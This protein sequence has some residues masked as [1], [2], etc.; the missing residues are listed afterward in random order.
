MKHLLSLHD[1]SPDA[2]VSVLDDADELKHTRNWHGAARPL[3]GRS[4]AMIFSKSSTRTRVSFEVGIFELGGNA[5]F[6]DRKAL[7]LGRGEPIADTA[8]VLSRYV[9]AIVIRYHSHADVEELAAGSAVPVINALTDRYHPCQ[10][11]ADLQTIRQHL[12]RLSG[13]KV[14]YLGDGASNMA[15]SWILGAGL[16]GIDLTVGAPAPYQ[17]PAELLT[18]VA[19]NGSV[20]VE[21]DP[22]RAVAGADIVY[23]DV[24]VSM[25]F[26]E[27]AEERLQ[28]LAP[29]QV[30]ADLLQ[31][32]AADV[33]V[34]HCLPA[35]RDKEI[36]A[37][38]LE[39]ERA[40]V[41][42]QAENRL[43]AQKA[44]LSRLVS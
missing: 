36:T 34:M 5:M 13:V 44:I 43:H 17:P 12:G 29:Y 42:D 19:G 35:Y 37:D 9:H 24:W 23:T 39:S 10:V 28:T 32:A 26:E 21:P 1:L 11:L 15:A 16:A 27:E 31:H 30:N 7:Q 20:T 3:K 38:V 33:R 25:G 40:I 18:A 4:V 2:V 41:W 14:A 22:R 6:F 8:R